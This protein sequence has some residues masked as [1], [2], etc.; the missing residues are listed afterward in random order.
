MLPCS[1]P[2]RWHNLINKNDELRHHPRDR[3]AA[4]EVQIMLPL[5]NRAKPR[6]TR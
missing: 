6:I 5:E 4:L 2:H 3:S 1:L